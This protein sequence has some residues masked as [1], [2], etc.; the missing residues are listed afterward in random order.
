MK[1]QSTRSA[2][3][4]VSASTA[5][6][7]GIAND[8]GLYVFN[9]LSNI[10]FDYKTLIGKTTEQIITEILSI[11]LTDFTKDEIEKMVAVAYKNKF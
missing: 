10:K 1:Y 11:F 4:F 8:G 3:S 2:D 6:L 9:S 7:S 5:I